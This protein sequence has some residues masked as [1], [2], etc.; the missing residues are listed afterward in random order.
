MEKMASFLL[1]G[2]GVSLCRCYRN[3]LQGRYLH[4]S[5]TE[6]AQMAQAVHQVCKTNMNT[7]IKSMITKTARSHVQP[8][9]IY[10]SVFGTKW[11][12]AI[13]WIKF[14]EHLHYTG[15]AFYWKGNNPCPWKCSY[16]SCLF[17]LRS[18]E[19]GGCWVREIC[20]DSQV[21]NDDDQI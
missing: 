13:R 3:P 8:G 6:R 18:S 20:W 11:T 9:S 2:M 14:I 10:R 12:K 16:V 1:D 17:S 15:K 19:S 7:I 4:E 5:L 21:D